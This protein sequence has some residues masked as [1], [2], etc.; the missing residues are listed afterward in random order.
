[1]VDHCGFLVSRRDAALMLGGISIA[2][3]K[4]LQDGPPCAHF[5]LRILGAG[6]LK[7]AGL[8]SIHSLIALDVAAI[9]KGTSKP[10]ATKAVNPRRREN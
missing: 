2:S 1:M 4:R 10:K 6:A 8:D 3:I 7:R 5:E 9:I